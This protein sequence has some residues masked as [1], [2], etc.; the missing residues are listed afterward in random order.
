MSNLVNKSA[1]TIGKTAAFISINKKIFLGLIFIVVVYFILK[2]IHG[3]SNVFVSL[4]NWM[5]K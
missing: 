4:E 5:S 1:T 2:H 3:W